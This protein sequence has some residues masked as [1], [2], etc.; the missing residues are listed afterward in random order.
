MAGDKVILQDRIMGFLV[1]AAEEDSDELLDQVNA[2][3]KTPRELRDE[4]RSKWYQM[5]RDS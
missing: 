1:E 3:G 4:M 2:A 5:D